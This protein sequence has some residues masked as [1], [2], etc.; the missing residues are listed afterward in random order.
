[1]DGGPLM[2][3]TELRALAQA[4]T[5]G[6]WTADVGD[7]RWIAGASVWADQRGGRRCFANHLAPAMAQ[8]I[9]ALSPSVIVA[10]L[11]VIAAG[12]RMRLSPN[13]THCP[14]CAANQATFD[15]ARDAL[16]EAMGDKP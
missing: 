12:D 2:T 13:H 7:P 5:P 11:D 3:L 16:D 1:M 14:S 8:Y 15:A 6:P 9:A 4:A 10:M